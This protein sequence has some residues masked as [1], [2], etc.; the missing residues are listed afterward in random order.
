MRYRYWIEN[1]LWRALHHHPAVELAPD[2]A[3]YLEHY[4]R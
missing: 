4:K 1:R 2:R 3:A